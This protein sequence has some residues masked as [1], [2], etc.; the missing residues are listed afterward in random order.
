MWKAK[1]NLKCCV[2]LT[3]VHVANTENWYFNNGCSRHMIGIFTKINECR[4]GRVTFRD[5]VEG[6]VVGKGDINQIGALK[7]TNVR[8]V[9]E[10]LANLISISQLC[11]QGF[12]VNFT[13]DSCE[14]VDGE[15][16]IVMFDNCYH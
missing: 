14:V 6:N 15:K 13:K 7:L 8:L 3:S 11:D 10:L 1:E 2:A 12:M 9:E 5:G 16:N 4:T